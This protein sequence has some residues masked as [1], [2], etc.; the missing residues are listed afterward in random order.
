[1]GSDRGRQ[2][3]DGVAEAPGNH[4][5]APPGKQS[6]VASRYPAL[7]SAL[8]Q[9]PRGDGEPTIH[10]AATA[11][12]EGK[13]SGASLDGSVAE[14]VGSHLG[15]DFSAVRVHGDPLSQQATQAMGARAFAYGGDVFLGPGESG[16]DLGLMAHELTHVVQQGAAGQ[17]MPQRAV[18]VG[19]ASSP[20]EHQADR[21][22]AEVTGGQGAPAAL[23][24]DG[25]PV[26]SGQMLKSQF[27]DQLRAQVMTAA[28]AELGPVYAP[29]GCPPIEQFFSRSAAE[30][31]AAS[32]ARLKR[33]APGS[34][35]A[36]TATEMIPEL[37]A[38]MGDG[39]RAWRDTGKVPPEL[40]AVDPAASAA[41]TAAGGPQA[42]ALRAP[43]GSETLASLEA[44]LGPGQPL[45]GAT[46]HRMSGA[47]GVDVSAARIH[48]G[49]V[50]ARKAA[51]A[52]A[53][54]FAV[55]G[56]VV[57][58]AGAPPGGTLE[59]DALL[60][61]ELAHTAQQAG[62]AADPVA[63]RQPIRGESAAAEVD[64]D[65]AA[66]GAVEQLH[67]PRT[68]LVQRLGGTLKTGL[69]LQRCPDKD[70]T[71]APAKLPK[72]LTDF[73]A[74]FAGTE[75]LIVKDKAA[76][77]L[78]NEAAAAGVKYGGYAEDGPAK[79]AWAYTVG[80]SVYVPKART[81]KIVA[82]SDFLFELNN[83]VRKP[84]F[85]KIHEE[86]AKG[87]KGS[88]TAEQYATQ[89]VELEVE[90]ML[91]M[92][93]IWFEMKKGLGGD[94]KFDKYDGDFFLAQYNAF[95]DGKKTKAEIVT[96]V[97]A[98]KN[99]IESSKTNK[100]YYMDQYNSLSGG[101]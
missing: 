98:W 30:S 60:A 16:G 79:A 66:A 14:R 85:D 96:D 88:L 62:A 9:R 100:Q 6:L 54:A 2:E 12:V 10:D 19:D 36:R 42:Q 48:T 75:D 71:A 64:A 50:A 69:Q 43:D 68:G 27:L 26:A 77:L 67:A 47:L 23:L 28:E 89:K 17:R 81:D 20:A 51:D 84:K 94:S 73:T 4:A 3:A 91:R 72:L 76:L 24:V 74:A 93:E 99:G 61:H 45:E 57:M 63:R 40:G 44:E 56:N 92:G 87:S 29:L 37:V 83:A 39:V 53:A 32:E 8:T 95:K 55:G 33:L 5:A 21:V 7:A 70:K 34:R 86:A 65:A 97:L 49:P 15:A 52:G 35:S 41:A 82:V 46:A 58:G 101:K 31:A 25:G 80:D 18:Q 11:A 90:G 78:V 13:G 59:G 1:M 38:R 22:A